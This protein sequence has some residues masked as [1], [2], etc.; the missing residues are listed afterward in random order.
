MSDELIKAYKTRNAVVHDGKK[1]P[2]SELQK[3]AF[4]A[5]HFLMDAYKFYEGDQV[6]NTFAS[7]MESQFLLQR[8]LIGQGVT[9]DFLRQSDI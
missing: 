9:I 5:L 6:L 8:E 4:D 2:V 1:Y 3:S 7:N